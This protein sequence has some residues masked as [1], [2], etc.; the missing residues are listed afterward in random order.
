MLRIRTLAINFTPRCRQVLA[1]A[2]LLTCGVTAPAQP[3]YSSYYLYLGDHPSSRS[4]GF[5]KNVQGIAHDNDHWYISQARKI[6]RIPVSHNLDS[7]SASDPGVSVLSITSHPVLGAYNHIGDIV[8][9]THRGIDYL[10]LPLEG[11]NLAPAI[12]VLRCN[13][14]M[15]YIAHAPI[16]TQ[17]GLA[18]VAV[19]NRGSLYSSE[20]SRPTS[21]QKYSVEWDH[22]YNT[23]PPVLSIRL[24]DDYPIRDENGSRLVLH[25][26]QGGEFSPEGN[27]LYVSTGYY[28]DTDPVAEGIHVFDAQSWRRVQHSTNGRGYFNYQFELDGSIW[29]EAEGL[30]I[31]D[32]DDGRAP[33][34]RGQLHVLLLDNNAG[35]PDE[36]C[37]K[38]YRGT[39]SVDHTHVGME[40]GTPARPFNTVAEASGMAWNGAQIN[41][42]AGNYLEAVTISER[43]RLTAEGDIVRIGQ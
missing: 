2:A 38:H 5:H 19:D 9:Y 21:F 11:Q 8:C 1:T 35:T 31:W 25:S 15:T 17:K 43:V 37:L 40:D 24:V 27:L 18:W 28:K 23:F 36:I 34:I 29:D 3:F 10:I 30:T 13:S 39:I 14:D 16:T 22:L 6:W 33:G 7:V 41:I 26:A 32:L 12:A 20:F 4:P 42:R